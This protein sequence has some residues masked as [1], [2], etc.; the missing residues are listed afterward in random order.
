MSNFKRLIIAFPN[1][2]QQKKIKH[3]INLPDAIY[4]I[5]NS[6]LPGE[7]RMTQGPTSSK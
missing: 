3:K 7:A 2:Q 5:S 4:Q 1:Q 6:K